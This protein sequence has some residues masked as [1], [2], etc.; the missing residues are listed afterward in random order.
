MTLTNW[1][2]NV[3]FTPGDYVRATSVEQVQELVAGAPRVRVLGS[4]HSFST[5]AATDGLLLS[6]EDLPL[7]VDVDTAAAEARVTASARFAHV[8]PALH[9]AGLALHNTGSLPHISVAGAAATG[10]HG[11]GTG[12][13]CLAAGITGIELIAP[14]G[15]LRTLRT[16]DKDFDGSVVA[17]GL[18]GVVTALTLKAQPAF[19]VRQ[20]VYDDLPLAALAENFGEIMN[21][22]YSVSAFTHWNGPTM[23]LLW[24]KQ[25]V[26][27]PE[28]PQT[29]FGARLADGARHPIAGMPTEN[30]TQQ[31]GVPGPWHERLPHFRFEFTPSRGDE[32]QSEFLLPIEQAGAALTA[33]DAVHPQFRPA[34]Q[35]A[36]IRTIAGDDLW[37]SP[38]YGRT[39]VAFHF[40]WTDD[41][42]E[43]TPAI[44]AVESALAD[45]DA[46][47][48]WGKVF[49]LSREQVRSRYPR[50]DDFEELV[51]RVDPQGKFTNAFTRAYLDLPA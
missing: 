51:N 44:A 20:Y 6:L 32:I 45:F 21:S 49:G 23:D 41:L 30:A 1:A 19:D 42:S 16:G 13:R 47:P 18:A 26:D 22:A 33:L 48:H 11:S 9:Q 2:G 50:L 34:L 27:E 39:T 10:T 5:V 12:N 15:S 31:L 17:L 37:L 29:Y 40:T 38:A 35:V 8:M 3:V 24:R 46:R 43:V 25:R 28:A 14:D 36:E 4:G 7:S